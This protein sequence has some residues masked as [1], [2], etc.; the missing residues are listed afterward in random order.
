[1]REKKSDQSSKTYPSSQIYILKETSIKNLGRSFNKVISEINH[2]VP[3]AA[4]KKSS[5]LLQGGTINPTS[6][7]GSK[8]NRG[9]R[10]VNF[11][12]IGD[13]ITCACME[14]EY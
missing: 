1:M 5:A 14:N 13:K 2:T 7:E 6:S 4:I 8:S 12:E 3:L 9:I 11:P 10:V